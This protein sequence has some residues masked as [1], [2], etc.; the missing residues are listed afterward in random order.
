MMGATD[1]PRSR[2]GRRPVVGAVVPDGEAPGHHVLGEEERALQPERP[3]DEA[4]YHALVR[5]AGDHLDHPPGEVE[6][7]LLYDHTSPSEV[8]CG[9]R[10]RSATMRSSASSPAP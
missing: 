9:S 6:A 1:R 2:D 3:E 8:S 7:A 10:S 5:L 4:A